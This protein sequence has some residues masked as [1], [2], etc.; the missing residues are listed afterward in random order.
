MFGNLCSFGVDRIS[1]AVKFLLPEFCSE[2]QV[3]INL[4]C[5]T[6]FSPRERVSHGFCL[7][8]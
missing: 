2:I 1:L 3:Q 5:G 6:E 7:K 4:K 8:Q